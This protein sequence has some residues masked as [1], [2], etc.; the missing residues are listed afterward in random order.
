MFGWHLRLF[1]ARK[2]ILRFIKPC[3][4]T[5]TCIFSHWQ[6]LQDVCFRAG[7]SHYKMIKSK[8]Q[9]AHLVSASHLLTDTIY[10]LNTSL[11][12]ACFMSSLM[13]ALKPCPT[14]TWPLVSFANQL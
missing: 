3:L 10:N 5:S 4:R 6:M 1:H 13:T 7:V 11:N 14:S 8:H 9:L 12:V 2:Q